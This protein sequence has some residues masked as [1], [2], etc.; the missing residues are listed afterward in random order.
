MLSFINRNGGF[1]NFVLKPS[2]EGGGNNYFDAE[3]GEFIEKTTEDELSSFILME[4]IIPV[5][6]IGMYTEAGSIK[7]APVVHEFGIYCSGVWNPDGEMV[8]KEV[9]DY[10]VRGKKMEDNEG[11]IVEGVGF[12]NSFTLN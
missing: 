1:R 3:I 5:E 6:E 2:R 8:H 10:F 4:R 7:I 9:G 11:P 12:Y